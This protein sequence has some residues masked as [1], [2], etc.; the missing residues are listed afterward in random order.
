MGCLTMQLDPVSCREVGRYSGQRNHV[1]HV[2]IVCIQG[3]WAPSGPFQ[4]CD[5]DNDYVPV[6]SKIPGVLTKGL[7]YVNQQ[8]F[9]SQA[10]VQD[11]E[12]VLPTYHGCI[13]CCDSRKNLTCRSSASCISL[14]LIETWPDHGHIQDTG[15]MIRKRSGTQPRDPRRIDRCRRGRKMVM[16]ERSRV[17]Q[18]VSPDI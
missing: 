11:F 14:C 18:E 12:W 3:K 15:S 4:I 5:R 16:A 8:K 13:T 6:I 17:N 10:K 1:C 2:F 7:A 9:R